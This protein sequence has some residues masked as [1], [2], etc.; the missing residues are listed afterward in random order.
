MNAM[1]FPVQSNAS[2][3][4]RPKRFVFLLLNNF[5]QL[6][7]TCALEALSLA[8]GYKGKTYYSW[9]TVSEDGNPVAS[10]NGMSINVDAG[11]CSLDRR[12]TI[13]VCGGANIAATS[14][15]KI[16]NWLRRETR[17]GVSCGGISSAAYTLAIAGLLKDKH[18]TIHWEHHKAFAEIF[19]EIEL[20]ET[21]FSVENNRFT[22]AGGASSIDMILYM[23]AQDYGDDLA[24]WVA[25]RMVYT[26]PRTMAH[27]QKMAIHC[28]TG[29]RHIKF[30]QAIDMMRCNIEAPL[31]PTRVAQ[32]VGLSARQL[33]R[34]FRKN[35]NT[36][37][38]SFYLH[39]RLENARNLLLQ[40]NMSIM[41]IC[42]STGFN[43]SSH[44]SRCYRHQFGVSPVSEKLMS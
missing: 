15:L 17:K 19:P 20:R 25:D 12:D 18:A 16:L 11:L 43:S 31:S 35:L 42:L 21:I 3:C 14:T 29:A 23:I 24:N 33:E 44:F 38:K 40:T 10:E 1:Q 26:T 4:H 6:G 5:S 13:V 32:K 37:P 41:D 36:T 22:C 9:Q 30:S 7:F 39:L 27:T 28:R 34:L 2:P 8:N